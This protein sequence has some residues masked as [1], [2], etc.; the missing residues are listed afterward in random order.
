MVHRI[1]WLRIGGKNLH[2]LKLVGAFFT[3]GAVLKVAESAYNIFVTVE[4][5]RAAMLNPQL[6]GQ[7]FGWSINSDF[8][9]STFTNED[10]LGVMLGPVAT[11]LFW[12]GIAFV[13]FV[14]YQSGR[15]I[16]PIE[17]YEQKVS[18]HHQN[19]IKKVLAHTK[20]KR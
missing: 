12:L 2:L 17:E 3:L 10:F 9:S 4:K 1:F 13:A 7:L 20:K 16:V 14:I 18:T 8:V 19:L 15:V 5:A 6:V 11:F